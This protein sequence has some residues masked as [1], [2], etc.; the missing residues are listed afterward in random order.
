M[1]GKKKNILL[2][3][4][5]TLYHFFFYHLFVHEPKPLLEDNMEEHHMSKVTLNHKLVYF[6]NQGQWGF[7]VNSTQWNFKL[8]K[9]YFLLK[10]NGH[11]EYFFFQ[12]LVSCLILR[13][14]LSILGNFF[15]GVLLYH[16][17]PSP[18]E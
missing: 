14:I 4:D 5:E 2:I 10:V 18:L 13:E 7:W 15:S 3:N 9:Q 8:G 17:P 6:F 1:Y 12:I 11:E 16:Y